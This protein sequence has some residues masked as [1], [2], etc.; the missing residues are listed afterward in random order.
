MFFW[1]IVFIPNY[2]VRLAELIIPA[3]DLSQHISTA[4]PQN[5]VEAGQNA[6]HG[7]SPI[8]FLLCGI[9]SVFFRG[10]CVGTEASGTSCMKF[11][12]NGGLIIGT[13]DGANVEI[14]EEVGKDN[15]FIFGIQ[16]QQIEE[17]RHLES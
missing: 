9:G 4:G 14:L 16:T 10:V 15:I 11:A 3:N 2:N 17:T 1:Q 8:T 5:R 7:L 13:L 6:A 12:M